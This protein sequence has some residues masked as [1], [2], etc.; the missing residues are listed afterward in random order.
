MNSLDLAEDQQAVGFRLQEITTNLPRSLRGYQETGMPKCTVSN[1]FPSPYVSMSD[2][3]QQLVMSLH[4]MLETPETRSILKYDLV[5]LNIVPLIGRF[6]TSDSVEAIQSL[7]ML[8]QDLISWSLD[9]P[10]IHED[11]VTN[12]ARS[13]IRDLQPKDA[14]A[15]EPVIRY[16]LR[17]DAMLRQL[18]VPFDQVCYTDTEAWDWED[19][20]KRFLGFS[21]EKAEEISKVP[22][23]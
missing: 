13:L 9:N 22:D 12:L 1:I 8:H 5:E 14:V 2:I 4:G 17:I 21:S 16:G 3:L 15:L 18:R 20:R 11:R 7:D 23:L 10:H 19:F 6:Y